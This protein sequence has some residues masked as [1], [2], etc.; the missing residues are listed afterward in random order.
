MFMPFRAS[1]FARVALLTALPSA[2]L[3]LAACGGGDSGNSKKA[4]ADD[5]VSDVCDLAKDA[6]DRQDDIFA[7][8]AEIDFAEKG[9]KDDL[10]DALEKVLD[11][12]E[13]LLR[14]FDDDI[15]VP[16][17][18]KGK[19]VRAAF[20]DDIEDNVRQLKEA[21]KEIKKLDEG[22]DFEDDVNGVFDEIED[23]DLRDVL[24]DINE[25]DVDDLIDLVDEDTDCS[26]LVFNS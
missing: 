5:W 20:K 22:D 4:D 24:E 9:A 14:D 1:N 6:G 16:D 8:L 21:I 10:V 25:N 18:E 3:L 12:Q 15:G 13:S 23:E 26:A 17:I 7:D 11:E 2:V 19:D